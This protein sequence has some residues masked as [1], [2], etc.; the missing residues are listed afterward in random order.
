MKNILLLFLVFTFL[1]CSNPKK[2]NL[3][4]EKI[5]EF[6]NWLYSKEN[7]ID[8]TL[9]FLQADVNTAWRGEYLSDIAAVDD[10]KENKSLSSKSLNSFLRSEDLEEIFSESNIAFRFDSVLMSNHI[11]LLNKEDIEKIKHDPLDFQNNG[12]IQ[13]AGKYQGFEILSKPIFF[14]DY[15]Y[16]FIYLETVSLD[17]SSGGSGIGFYENKNGKWEKVA[18][19]PLNMAG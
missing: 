19:I 1:G 9:V 7:L 4:S 5:H 15:R 12:I 14:Q 3:E 8:D 16:C 13:F 18:V 17:L 2:S 6:V 10:L 11:Q